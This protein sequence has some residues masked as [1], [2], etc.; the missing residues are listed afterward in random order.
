[1]P[2]AAD[3]GSLM[4]AVRALC[5]SGR[6]STVLAGSLSPVDER[7][8]NQEVSST[9]STAY[10]EGSSQDHREMNG[11]CLALAPSARMG[12]GLNFFSDSSSSSAYFPSC[13]LKKAAYEAVLKRESPHVKKDAKSVK[14]GTL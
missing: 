9:W 8:G 6:T 10:I 7:P 14:M 4:P 12:E 1:M 2:L 5:A 13:L 3:F 11:W